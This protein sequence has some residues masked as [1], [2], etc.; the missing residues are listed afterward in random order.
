M[1]LEVRRGTTNWDELTKKFKVTFRFENNNPLIKLTLQVIKNKIFASEDLLG[2][3]PLYSVPR[4]TAIVEEVL[5]Y[6]NIAEEDHNE[7]DPR[8]L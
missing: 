5:H 8:K 2:S 7:E 4:F 6:Y 1:E 3:I